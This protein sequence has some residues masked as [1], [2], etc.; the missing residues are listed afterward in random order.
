MPHHIRDFFLKVT[1]SRTCRTVQDVCSDGSPGDRVHKALFNQCLLKEEGHT[2]SK[3][4]P[5]PPSSSHYVPSL[6][7][8]PG[9]NSHTSDPASWP[10]VFPCLSPSVHLLFVL[11]HC[12]AENC[13][14]LILHNPCALRG[15]APSKIND[16]L[17]FL[18][19]T[20]CSTPFYT[21]AYI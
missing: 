17:V 16:L 6:N 4:H 12:C 20:Q 3:Q 5:H 1:Q 11:R 18:T 14:K 21:F 2:A 13:G 19:F 15:I 10:F 7:N 8:R 9:N